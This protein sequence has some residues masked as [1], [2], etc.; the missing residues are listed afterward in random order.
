ME[1]THI[2]C[3]Q[4]RSLTGVL[5]GIKGKKDKQLVEAF[6]LSLLP[7]HHDVSFSAPQHFPC[8][9]GLKLLKL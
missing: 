4:H 8:H 3:G 6:S 1:K 2:E 5:D 7:G 9:Y